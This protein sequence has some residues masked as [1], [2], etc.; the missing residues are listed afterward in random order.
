MT[1]NNLF[2]ARTFCTAFFGAM[3]L[4][5]ACN[6]STNDVPTPELKLTSILNDNAS[7][8]TNTLHKWY[9]FSKDGITQIDKP[10]N[11]PQLV[12]KAWTECLRTS[13]CAT[14]GDESYLL[15]NRLGLYRLPS[16]LSLEPELCTDALY[17]T[18]TTVSNL[19]A[20]QENPVFHVYR[21]SFF[22]QKKAEKP[23]PFLIQY[24]KD[25]NIFFPLLKVT[26][27]ALD[28]SV[29]TVHLQ[30]D[31]TNWTASFK[32]DTDERTHFTYMQFFTYE[33]LISLTGSPKPEQIQKQE[34]TLEK[35]KTLVCQ[36]DYSSA[37]KRVQNL[38][39]QIPEKY[40]LELDYTTK[41][42]QTPMHFVRESANTADASD[43]ANTFAGRVKDNGA[44]IMAL[45]SD[46]TLYFC[47]ALDGLPILRNNKPIAL[48]LPKMQAGFVYTDFA[49]SSTILYAAWEEELFYQTGRA[50]FVA[51]DLKK[52]LYDALQE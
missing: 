37:P 6:K 4:F 41:N 32:Q 45:F 2:L 15:A 47:G 50:G 19:I 31:G 36:F 49:L 38:L 40:G 13:A 35:F 21:N 20:I 7:A 29:E 52:V 30:F 24:R 14:I 22:N 42:P 5:S 27:L 44:S 48:R 18:D 26:D 3:L 39:S 28:P 10:E 25:T 33:P 46:G 8:K 34:L 16:S 1:K 23:L 11:A 12:F 17:F 43:T 51:I 9:Y